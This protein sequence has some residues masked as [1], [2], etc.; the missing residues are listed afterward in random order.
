LA[1]SLAT[2]TTTAAATKFPP[3]SALMF[4]DTVDCCYFKR[5][6]NC[7]RPTQ[8]KGLPH[9]GRQKSHITNKTE[10]PGGSKK[11]TIFFSGGDKDG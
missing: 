5:K 8:K 2:T 9:L 10:F 11:R 7:V 1:I 3:S 6:I 4:F